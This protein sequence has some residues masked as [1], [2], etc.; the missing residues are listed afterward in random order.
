MQQQKISAVQSNDVIATDIVEHKARPQSTDAAITIATIG[1]VNQYAYLPANAELY[2]NKLF[3]FFPGTL[4]TPVKY[5][6]VLQSAARHGYHAIGIA[7]DNLSTIEAQ[8][9][10]TNDDKRVEN[11]FE[12]YL[13]GNNTSAVVN[14]PKANGLENRIAKMIMYMDSVYPAENWKQFLT[15]DKKIKWQLLSVAGHS[16]GADHT[17]YISKKRN[18][19]R[20]TFFSGTYSFKL[21]NGAYPTFIS[22]AGLTPVENI[23]GFTHKKDPVRLW[24]DV[25]KN[26]AELEVPGKAT[27]IDDAVSTTSHK[28]VSNAKARLSVYHGMT[29]ADDGTPLDANGIPVFDSV[30]AYM[31]FP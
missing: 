30:W 8:A 22:N 29:V 7:Y 25:R 5:L 3:V 11:I 4:A 2:K 1:N 21:I 15:A 14:V 18:V 23:F 16:Q 17:M 10:E 31:C 27:L 20:A 28:L 9:G 26:W 19:Y 13:T 6:E 12:E 24:D